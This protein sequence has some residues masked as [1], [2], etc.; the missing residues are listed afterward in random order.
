[1]ESKEVYFDRYGETGRI[2]RYYGRMK[3][4]LDAEGS[5]TGYCGFIEGFSVYIWSRAGSSGELAENLYGII[6]RYREDDFHKNQGKTCLVA[7]KE[8]IVN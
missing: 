8:F 3:T 7:G 6:D 1:M 5:V 2:S 4:L